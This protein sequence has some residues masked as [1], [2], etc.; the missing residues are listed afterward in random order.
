MVQQELIG[1]IYFRVKFLPLVHQLYGA[2][3]VS[4]KPF[5]TKRKQTNDD[6]HCIEACCGKRTQVKCVND[7]Q[8]PGKDID[9][10]VHKRITFGLFQ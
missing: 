10:L 9:A 4:C 8:C 1:D 6:P 5:A 3:S 7:E 2:E